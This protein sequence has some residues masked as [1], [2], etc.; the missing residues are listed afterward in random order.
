MNWKVKRQP[1]H[2]QMLADMNLN[3]QKSADTPLGQQNFSISSVSV[4]GFS[5]L[6]DYILLKHNIFAHYLLLRWKV[7]SVSLRDFAI[8]RKDALQTR[9]FQ[10]SPFV[11]KIIII[12]QTIGNVKMCYLRLLTQVPWMP[13]FVSCFSKLC[14]DTFSQDINNCKTCFFLEMYGQIQNMNHRFS[15][16]YDELVL[17]IRNS[18]LLRVVGLCQPLLDSRLPA[19]SVKLLGGIFPSIV[20]KIP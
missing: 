4:G 14:E 16:F 18:F 13:P 20:T 17:S 6:E 8:T 9:R 10:L 15:C 5:D 2:L 12:D 11:I 1:L 19:K 3:F 7:D